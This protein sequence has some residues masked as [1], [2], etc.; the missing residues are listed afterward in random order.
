M[1]VFNTTAS[2]VLQ[3]SHPR[4]VQRLASPRFLRALPTL[5]VLTTA[6]VWATSSHAVG[7]DL[8]S[9]LR[10]GAGVNVAAGAGLGLGL[11]GGASAAGSANAGGGIDT[12]TGANSNITADQRAAALGT[13]G[14]HAGAD[15]SGAVTGVGQAAGRT[16]GGVRDLGEG[17]ARAAA[18]TG[19]G[20]VNSGGRVGVQGRA[21]ATAGAG[22]GIQG[23]VPSR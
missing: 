15:A 23:I 2:Q 4:L 14:V 7:L 16:L 22:A 6:L 21:G 1:S 17:A 3:T 8:D 5:M 13:A 11:G 18:R 19:Q 12:R 10:N 20:A 9:A